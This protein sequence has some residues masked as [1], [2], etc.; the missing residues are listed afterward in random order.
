ME[1]TIAQV[2]L[3]ELLWVHAHQAITSLV[4]LRIVG[5]AGLTHLVHTI[6]EEVMIDLSEIPS[7]GSLKIGIVVKVELKIKNIRAG[8]TLLDTILMPVMV[9]LGLI[10]MES[11]LKIRILVVIEISIEDHLL[12]I[13]GRSSIANLS[14]AHIGHQAL[15]EALVLEVPEELT[16][17]K[18]IEPWVASLVNLRIVLRAGLTELIDTI[19]EE[20]MEDLAVVP[21]KSLL[22]IRVLV[23][24]ELK[25][26]DARASTTLLDTIF[27]PV[28][29]ELG[30]IMVE[31]SLKIRILVVIEISIEH[32]LL[33]VHSTI[34]GNTSQHH[35]RKGLFNTIK[36]LK[37]TAKKILF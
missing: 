17:S 23:E 6:L 3:N 28:M 11:S 32:D 34:R 27:I 30:I 4:D 26:K 14:E 9:E 5:R 37:A 18:G 15:R 31:S 35:F 12:G 24:I 13:T 16:R 25:V 21:S 33:H 2:V 20:V 10:V 8:T 7:E 22:K 1:A 29:V 19:L 36:N